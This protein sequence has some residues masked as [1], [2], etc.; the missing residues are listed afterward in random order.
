MAQYDVSTM[1]AQHLFTVC[2]SSRAS[3]TLHTML[4]SPELAE[5]ITAYLTT[6]E[7]DED[8]E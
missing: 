6:P 4:V 7:S 1:P 5:S 2:H 3:I 8:V